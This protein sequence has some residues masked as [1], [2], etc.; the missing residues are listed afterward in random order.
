MDLFRSLVVTIEQKK[1]NEKFVKAIET[2]F[3]ENADSLQLIVDKDDFCSE[4][5]VLVKVNH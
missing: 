5:H 4:T 3:M 2:F 1:P